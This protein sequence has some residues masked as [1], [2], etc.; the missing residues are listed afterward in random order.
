MQLDYI[1][2]LNEYGDDMVRL[3]DFARAQA[4]QFIQVLR[5]TVFF[6]KKSL[7]LHDLNFIEARNCRLTLRISDENEGITSE[8][9]VN[10]FCD[11]NLETYGT[12]LTLLEP[13]SKRETKG[14]Q[15]LYDMDSPTDFLFSPG[16]TW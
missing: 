1:S 7:A 4:E 14:F 11:L 13:F 16:G 5:Q 9:N 2:D 8:N 3:Y 15:C 10:F 12:M 6:E